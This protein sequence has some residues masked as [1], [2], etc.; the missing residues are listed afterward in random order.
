M[1][2]LIISQAPRFFTG[3]TLVFILEAMG[4][5]LLMTLIGCS[6]GALAGFAISVLRSTTGQWLAPLR[7]LA[8][9]YVEVFRRIPFLVILFIVMYASQGFGS[10][11][12][13]STIATLSVCLVAT[14]FLSEIIRAGL[15]S[16]PRQQLEAA[17]VMNFGFARTLFRV[18]LP[19]SWKVILPPAFAFMV[20]FIKDTSLASQMGVVELTFA[21]KVLMNRGYSPFLVYAVVLAA[22]FTLSYP[23]S[24]LGAYLENRLASPQRRKSVQRVRA[25]TGPAERE[26][27][28]RPR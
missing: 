25:H 6:V 15:E 7:L 16:V 2:D 19:Q 26:L 5:T 3:Y 17:Q 8:T 12:S 20:M 21:G 18:L 23:L 10:T 13:L 9:F 22:Y 14:A 28:G 24:R 1:F 27:V 4:R 11:V